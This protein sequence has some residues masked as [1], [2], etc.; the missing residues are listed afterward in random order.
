[1]LLVLLLCLGVRLSYLRW[2][3][4]REHIER[5]GRNE[6]GQTPLDRRSYSVCLLLMSEALEVELKHSMA[7]LL[8]TNT[9]KLRVYIT[10][11]LYISRK[12]TDDGCLGSLE[13][14]ALDGAETSSLHL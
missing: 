12:T 14:N 6:V 9:P 1:M 4:E 3:E 10:P 2:R 8:G 7:R 11:H 13:L 5:E